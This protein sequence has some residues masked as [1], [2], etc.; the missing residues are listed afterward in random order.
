MNRP[1]TSTEIET[2]FKK[3]PKNKSLDWMWLHR[4]IL[5]NPEKGIN[6]Y[7]SET[8]SKNCRGRNTPKLIL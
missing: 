4:K 1:I 3:L 6:A 5:S 8:I 2:V 7:P